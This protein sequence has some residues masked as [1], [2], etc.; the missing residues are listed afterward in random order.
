MNVHPIVLHIDDGPTAR[1]AFVQSSV[2]TADGGVAIVSELTFG[3][4][5]V[6]DQGEAR[7]CP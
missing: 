5:V 4:G 6:N 1:W 3:V 2:E 7:T